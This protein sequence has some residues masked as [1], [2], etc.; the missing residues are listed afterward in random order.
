MG[1][2]DAKGVPVTGGIGVTSQDLVE[3]VDRPIPKDRKFTAVWRLHSNTT[4]QLVKAS[5]K[6]IPH[7]VSTGPITHVPILTRANRSRLQNFND[8]P[9]QHKTLPSEEK[10]REVTAMGSKALVALARGDRC[11]SEHYLYYRLEPFGIISLFTAR[12]LVQIVE[13]K[14]L[15]RKLIDLERWITAV[16]RKQDP[17]FASYLMDELFNQGSYGLKEFNPT[18]TTKISVYKDTFYTICSTNWL[19]DDAIESILLTLAR[20]YG[21]DGETLFMPPQLVDGWGHGK[22]LLAKGTPT[23]MFSIIHMGDHWGVAYFDLRAYTIAFGDSLTRAPPLASIKTIVDWLSSNGNRLA[24]DK[25]LLNIQLFPVQQQSDSFS[26]GILAIMAIER[27]CNLYVDWEPHTS[28]QAQ[29]IRFLRL[30]SNFS[31][32]EEDAFFGAY[33]KR[34]PMT[35][36]ETHVDEVIDLLRWYRGKQEKEEREWNAEQKRLQDEKIAEHSQRE[37]KERRNEILHRFYKRQQAEEALR[38]ENT[39]KSKIPGKIEDSQGMDRAPSLRK[40]IRPRPLRKTNI[41]ISSIEKGLETSA[42]PIMATSIMAT[43][44]MVTP[45]KATTIKATTVKATPV[46][47]TPVKATAVKAT[48]V[49][50]TTVKATTVKATTVMAP[51]IMAPS[52]MATSI[53]ATPVKA[54]SIMVTTV[55]ATPITA[56]PAKAIPVE[57][58]VTAK[59]KGVAEGENAFSVIKTPAS[60]SPYT[61]NLRSSKKVRVDASS[62]ETLLPSSKAT[63]EAI[64]VEI[65]TMAKRKGA[66]ED[67]DYDNVS[68]ANNPEYDNSDLYDGS[69]KIRQM[70]DGRASGSP[71]QMDQA[72]LVDSGAWWKKV[73]FTL[74]DG[75]EDD[76]ECEEEKKESSPDVEASKPRHGNMPTSWKPEVGLEFDS[77][78]MAKDCINSYAHPLGF[79]VSISRSSKEKGWGMYCTSIIVVNDHCLSLCVLQI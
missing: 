38:A 24:W 79:E 27:R 35:P 48:T 44:I 47:A 18:Y 53:T 3:D 19:S 21:Q 64:P 1:L 9:W 45:V 39:V 56:T 61:V 37:A 36:H 16:V 72:Q 10:L 58:K 76:S 33:W 49:K 54:T 70:P 5:D 29:R 23:R 59:R 13:T 42:S 25:A 8:F 69:D 50:A 43:S 15:A 52:I 67:P 28:P 34:H 17:A 73:N 7:C 75:E 22:A 62:T 65:K 68:D 20:C 4:G 31:K 26:C 30:L 40:S 14:K 32:I 74:E 57:T 77:F 71:L 2:A 51:S 6:L 12:L 46:K 78:E 63:P 60:V 55:K 66:V 41:A 11:S